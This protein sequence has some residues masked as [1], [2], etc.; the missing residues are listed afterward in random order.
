MD[1]TITRDGDEA[2]VAIA[3]RVD[4]NASAELREA[5]DTIPAEVTKVIFDLENMEYIASS[6]LRAILASLKTQKSKQGTVILS[7]PNGMVD[8]VLD[9]TGFKDIFELRP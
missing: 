2:V 6:G 8:D 4:T 9:A 7:K 5:I 3:G 1:V